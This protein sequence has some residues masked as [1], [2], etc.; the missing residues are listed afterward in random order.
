VKTLLIN[1]R[2]NESIQ[3]IL[4]E[5]DI[6]SYIGTNVPACDT[7][8]D[9]K[10]MT[11]IPGVIDPHTHIRDLKQWEKEDWTSAS[12]AA[13]RG[14]TTMVFDM[15]NTRPPTVNLEYLNL[16]REKAKAAKI[17]YRFNVAATQLNIPELIELLESKPG[18]VAALKL[19]LAGSNSNEYVDG[20]ETIKRIFDISLKYNLPVI[21]HTEMQKCVEAYASQ[22]NKPGIKDHN[23]IRNR[24]CSIQGTQLMID[25]ATEIGNAVYLAH[26]STAEE[27]QLVKENKSKCRVFCET[28]P[29]HLLINETILDTV[30]NYGKVNPPLRTK[31]DNKALLKGINDGTVDTIGTDHAP[32]LLSEKQKPYLEAPSGFPGLETSLPLLLNEVNKGSFGIQKLIEITSGN[33]SKIFGLKNRGQIK[34]GFFADLTVVDLNKPWKIQSKD[35]FTKAK[36][37]PFEGMTGKGD[38]V[39]TFVNGKRLFNQV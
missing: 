17:N 22:L 25:L 39:M 2:V 14:G 20:I 11:V 1:G 35:F 3:H 21:V 34:E 9:L 24:E 30:G 33:A 10:E 29:H 38:V 5:N 12:H 4:I 6:I 36:Y 28:T 18:D 8:I 7:E 37:S 23:Y 26:T 15:P 19:F 27:I 16:K 13:L 31:N 32:H